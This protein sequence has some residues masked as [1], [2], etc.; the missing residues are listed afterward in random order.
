MKFGHSFKEALEGAAYPSHWVERAI[1]YRELKKILIKVREELI[2]K[3]YDHDTLH[4]LLESRNAEYNLLA[5]DSQFLRPRLVVRPESN[6]SPLPLPELE[7]EPETEGFTT[8]TSLAES[9]SALKLHGNEPLPQKQYQ[10]DQ[11]GWVKIPLDADTRFFAVLQADVNELDKLQTKERQL[12]NDDI[13]VLGNEIFEVAKP[14]KGLF[15][16][17]KSDLYRWR[18]IFE[19]YLAAQ[20]FFST[21]ET[22]GG[23]RTSEKAR[24]QLVWFQDEVNKRRLLHRFKLEASA[25][26]YSRFLSLNSALLKNLQFQELNQTAVTK[27]IKKFD[28][29][30]SLGIKDVFPKAMNSAHFIAECISKDI[31]AQMSQEVLNIVPQVADYT[32]TICLSICWLPIQLDCRHTFCI[33][34]MIKM[35]NRN[36][37]LCPL[38]RANTVMLAT[39][40]MLSINPLFFPSPPLQTLVPHIDAKLMVFMERW[41]PKETKEKQTYN[42]IE[43]RKE[44]LG[45]TDIDTGCSIM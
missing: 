38:C 33:R 20:V 14:R 34:C 16:L 22:A 2:K 28:K 3:G 32:C 27:I 40:G 39:E 1:P 11:W 30:T 9:S 4:H 26:A 25:I 12:M 7:P 8:I 10:A 21:V 29:Q 36:K 17:S 15:H 19:L 5:G 42:E 24:K 6:T 18:E 43:R 41:F 31:C 23:T 13:H 35:Q 37:R 44:L 45:E